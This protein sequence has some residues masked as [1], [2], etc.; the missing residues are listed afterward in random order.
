MISRIHNSFIARSASGF[1]PGIVAVVLVAVLTAIPAWA[2]RAG[3]GGQARMIDIDGIA[4]VVNAEAITRAEVAARL[5]A[6]RRQLEARRVELPPID[7]LASQVLDRM[8]LDRVQ[9][10]RARELGIRVD[11]SQLD[12]LFA[13]IA[14]ER[15]LSADA[16]RAR[17]EA[18]GVS[19]RQ[20]LEQLQVD[21]IQSRLREREV[22]P[23]VQISESDIDAYVAERERSRSQ[24][25]VQLNLSQIL[26]RVSEGASADE[27]QRRRARAEEVLALARRP[28]ADFAALAAAYSDAGDAMAGGS[29]GWRTADRLPQLFVDAIREQ[30]VGAVVLARSPNGFHVLKVDGRRS[31][32]GGADFSAPVNQIRAR[33]I[34]LRIGGEVG[35]P[36]AMQ[37]VTEIRDMIASRRIDFPAAA[38]AYSEDATAARGGDLDWLLPGDTVPEFERALNALQPG[39]LSAPVRTPF[40]FHLIEVLERK[41]ALASPERVRAAARQALREQRIDEAWQDWLRQL[42]DRAY[43][44]IRLDER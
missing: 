3:A 10:Q 17:L 18:E 4:A 21:L 6:V 13:S 20:Y 7:V 22:E 37:R 14:A 8:I 35:E 28:S 15:G 38:K 43:V 16:F 11:G 39:E 33:H 31:E 19:R 26:V 29:L 2:Q 44:E 27:I 23:R 9:S 25:A 32:Q 30:A 5:D 42:R 1:H 12:R 34:L 40:G 36:Q 41:V 24:D